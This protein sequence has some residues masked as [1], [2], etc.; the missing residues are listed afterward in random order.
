VKVWGKGSICRWWKGCGMDLKA[1]PFL[2]C[3]SKTTNLRH[4]FV[5]NY[6]WKTYIKITV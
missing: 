2:L 5:K 6:C 4:I 1:Q 3:F